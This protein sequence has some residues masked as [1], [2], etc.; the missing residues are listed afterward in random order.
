MVGS[1]FELLADH[2]E[3]VLGGEGAQAAE[4]LRRIV[5]GS[6]TVS[7]RLARRRPFDPE[8]ALAALAQAWDDGMEAIGRALG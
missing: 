7:F 4:A 3:Y 6:K 5:E 2:V 8:P 1:A